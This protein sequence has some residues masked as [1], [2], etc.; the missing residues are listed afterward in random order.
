[1][2]LLR[3]TTRGLRTDIRRTDIRR[4]DLRHVRTY[5]RNN[6][7]NITTLNRKDMDDNLT[8]GCTIG[9]FVGS[10]CFLYKAPH[11]QLSADTSITVFIGHYICYCVSVMS[12]SF[13]CST[14]GWIW[15]RTLVV[16][17]YTNPTLGLVGSGITA[18][19]VAY[20][21]LS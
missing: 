7:R 8:F 15:G 21:W 10:G 18:C 19:T 5:L 6:L 12:L 1:M 11:I 3:Q 9:A 4:N 17:L 20:C 14:V 2:W 16:L 13:L